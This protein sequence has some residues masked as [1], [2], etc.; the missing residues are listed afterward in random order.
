MLVA[1]GAG[2]S[3]T[4]ASGA[5]DGETITTVLYPGWNLVGWVG[6]DTQTSDLFEAIP[7]LRQVWSWDAEAQ[8]Y[9]HARRDYA[10]NLPGLT[11]GM[12][13]WLRLGGNSTYAWMRPMSDQGALVDLHRGPNLLGWTGEDG[14]PVAD[15]LD[16]FGD[17]L[18]EV[19][20]WDAEA[21][22]YVPY[23]PG[24]NAATVATLARGQALRI[25]LAQYRRWWERGLAQ[26][27]FVFAEGV[28]YERQKEVQWLFEHATDLIA[29][30]FGVHT[31]DYRVGVPG[32]GTLYCTVSRDAPDDRVSVC[33]QS[34]TA[35]EYFLI[36]QNALAAGHDDSNFGPGWLSAGTAE[37]VQHVYD[38]ESRQPLINPRTRPAVERL[39]RTPG[40]VHY[41]H[42]QPF[43]LNRTTGFLAAEWLADH[44]GEESLAEFYRLG[45]S[46]D[47]WQD[48][49]R[50]A[51][52]IDLDDFYE[53]LEAY[54][55]ERAPVDPH[56]LDDRDEVIVVPLSAAA[57][58]VA[59]D[60]QSEV[61]S[62]TSF[63]NE[64]FGARSQ[65]YT[66]YVVDKETFPSSFVSAFGDLT[67]CSRSARPVI[68]IFDCEVPEGYAYYSPDGDH[69]TKLINSHHIRR[70]LDDLAPPLSTLHLRRTD[71][72]VFCTWGIYWICDGVPAYLAA[73]YEVHAGTAELDDVL[74]S[75]A[76]L[77][78]GVT[79]PLNGFEGGLTARD[80]WATDA[81]AESA[82]LFLAAHQLAS[83]AGDRA[84]LEYFRVLPTAETIYEAFEHAF[85]MTLEEFYEQFEA[86]R[87]ALATE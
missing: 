87:A 12:G 46:H 20:H 39:T 81:T 53:S 33:A 38:L 68:V 48:A 17:D 79:K 50:E 13:L 73:I 71:I 61:A 8:A 5:D 76:L 11:F 28:T 18:E 65:D 6:P 49:F 41:F 54:R 82:L 32:D 64:R 2:V 83:H 59:M 23:P 77:A 75:R 16:R 47:R 37:Y 29:M 66:I 26:P 52:R 84:L 30:R 44:A 56:L 36:L 25:E 7:A 58:P 74:H 42:R 24:S 1:A 10:G 67:F 72:A 14:A 21:Q 22:R 70:I 78:G 69:Y 19:W 9:R 45:R 51:F 60:I 85:G 57:G 31:T 62:L 27:T 4:A 43:W 63:Y 15:A 35:Y 86:Y 55:Y 34:T 3:P 80:G 40:E